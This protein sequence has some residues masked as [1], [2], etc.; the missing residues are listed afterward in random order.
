VLFE[1]YFK[2]DSNFSLQLANQRSKSIQKHKNQE[3]IQVNNKRSKSL[4][5]VM[6]P[7]GSENKKLVD[8]DQYC[9]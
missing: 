3:N 2:N 5:Q 6:I 7:N 4:Q 8:I 9:I 1:R